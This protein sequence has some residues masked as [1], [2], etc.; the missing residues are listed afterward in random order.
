MIFQRDNESLRRSARAFVSRCETCVQQVAVNFEEVQHPAVFEDQIS[1][2]THAPFPYELRRWSRTW[3]ESSR[4]PSE[5]CSPESPGY[6]PNFPPQ[7]GP[8]GSSRV[9]PFWASS[10]KFTTHWSILHTESLIYYT[11][12]RNNSIESYTDTSS[13]DKRNARRPVANWTNAA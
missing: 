5:L 11:G 8:E 10:G 12:F 6:R 3:L 1:L 4:G 9:E 13:A 2:T 7:R